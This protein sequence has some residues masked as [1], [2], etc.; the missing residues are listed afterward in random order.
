MTQPIPTLFVVAAVFA[1]L[2]NVLWYRA[3]FLLRSRGY[4][5]SYIS[6]FQD[7]RHLGQLIHAES[8]PATRRRYRRLQVGLYSALAIML[9]IFVAVFASVISGTSRPQQQPASSEARS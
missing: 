3:K 8:D 5:M 1:M 6:H 4:P 2:T 7:L 9:C